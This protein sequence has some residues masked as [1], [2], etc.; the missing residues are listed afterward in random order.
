MRRSDVAFPRVNRKVLDASNL[1]TQ[2]V[3]NG[4][5]IKKMVFCEYHRRLEWVADFY[6]ESESKRKGSDD[7]RVLCIEGWDATEGKLNF[8]AP[9]IKRPK[10][11]VGATL[12]EFFDRNK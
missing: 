9:I 11:E 1:Y 7:V 2:D 10:P 5:T 12:L 8:N 6:L 3:E 4:V